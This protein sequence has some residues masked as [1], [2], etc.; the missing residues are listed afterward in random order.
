M[1][2]RKAYR[3]TPEQHYSDAV[4]YA[5]FMRRAAERSKKAADAGH[6]ASALDFFGLAMVEAGRYGDAKGYSTGK[7]ANRA[8][9]QALPTAAY[10]KLRKTQEHLAKKCFLR[11]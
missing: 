4:Q 5:K 9:V 3:G 2:K 10:Q 1:A 8:A 6:C 7:H 11:R